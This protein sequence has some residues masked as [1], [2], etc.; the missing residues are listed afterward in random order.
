MSA[1]ANQLAV[2]NELSSTAQAV[3]DESGNQTQL[4]VT[5]GGNIGIG[6]SN[7]Q[8]PLHVGQYQASGG[9]SIGM[10]RIAHTGHGG[11]TFKSW[12]LGIADPNVGSN[13][14]DAFSFNCFENNAIAIVMASNGN[15]GI[16]NPNPQQALDVNGTVKATGLQISGSV[17][18][19]APALTGL[20]PA[21]T[22]PAGAN[23]ESVF[24]D[25][26]TGILYYQ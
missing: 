24:V 5:D 11:S 26:N 4:Y 8:Q 1:P 7:P 13:D 23:L 22:A 19:N 16:K 18:L 14:P 9:N 2:Q 10:I 15:V 6:T 17:T 3:Q 12:D 20:Q 25:T 21:S